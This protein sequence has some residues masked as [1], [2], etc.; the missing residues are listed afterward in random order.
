MKDLLTQVLQS[1]INYYMI[2]LLV[3]FNSSRQV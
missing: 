2:Q 1:C 3:I